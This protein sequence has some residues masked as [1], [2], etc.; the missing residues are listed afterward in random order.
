[1]VVQLT[2]KVLFELDISA[3]LRKLHVRGNS[4]PDELARFERVFIAGVGQR[5]EA[6]IRSA[7]A[8]TGWP[9]ARQLGGASSDTVPLRRNSNVL[10]RLADIQRDIC[11]VI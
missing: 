3:G 6:T 5:R 10:Y 11:S 1:M 4:L 8:T 2:I 9:W 7:Y